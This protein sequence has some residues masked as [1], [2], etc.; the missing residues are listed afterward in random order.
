MHLRVARRR[1]LL[2]RRL[3]GSSDCE[4]KKEKPSVKT[5]EYAYKTYIN[6]H[7]HPLRSS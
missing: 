6:M 5:W 1:N 4:K 3:N 2:R 7:Q